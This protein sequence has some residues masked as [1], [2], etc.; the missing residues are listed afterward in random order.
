MY[1][2][3]IESEGLAHY[4][5][6]IGDEGEA[7]VID[8][9][10]DV[11]IYLDEAREEGLKIKYIFETHRN[12]DYIIGSMELSEKTNAPIYISGHEDL[13]YEYGEK[14][15][16]GDTFE[17]GN[18]KIK[19][20]H[21]PGHTL[22]HLCYAFY[23]GQNDNPLGVFTGDCLFM[24][25]LGRTDFYGEENLDEMTG[26]LYDSIFETLFSL[27]EGV[28]VFP[29]HGA[30]SACGDDMEDRPFSTIG[31]E[32]K[33]NPQLQVSSREEFIEEFGKMRI[34]PRYF[35]K[36]EVFNVKGA[37][38]VGGDITISPVKL[39]EVMD[40]NLVIL[41]C[42]GKEAFWGGHIPGSYF[43]SV[44]NFTRF[45]GNLFPLDTP[46]V[47]NVSSEDCIL[48]ELY[49][50]ARRIGFDNIKGYLDEGVD[51]VLETDM[52]LESLPT[53]KPK[54]FLELE[55]DFILLDVRLPEDIKEDSLSEQRVNI[56][57]QELYKD[58]DKLD[59]DKKIYVVCASGDRATA[60]AAFIKNEGYDPTVV[61]GGMMALE[62]LV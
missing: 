3:K 25:D 14:I 17:V 57:L 40:S 28:L 42:R 29:A 33:N 4:S 41:D 13:G 20:I 45:A 55:K 39:E 16:D 52:T 6:I 46:L 9:R 26:K 49:W 11:E 19:A 18:L 54:E 32:K 37:P 1:F 27:G 23:H 24:G 15:F 50:R 56:P 10:R 53:I 8:P 47:L 30:G 60:G 31:Y 44:R 12:E 7:A 62:P 5:Y 58:F 48:D 21:T 51:S 61:I 2:K 35:E 59:K 22:G 36:M 34:K 38:F 43:L